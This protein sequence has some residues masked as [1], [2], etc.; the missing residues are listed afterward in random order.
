MI[1]ASTSWPM[2]SCYCGVNHISSLTGATDWYQDLIN[3]HSQHR[4][5]IVASKPAGIRASVCNHV[6]RAEEFCT[7]LGNVVTSL[8]TL[9]YKELSGFD[10]LA[11]A[12][13]LLWG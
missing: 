10:I 12:F 9:I 13:L 8:Y 2:L 6:L 7:L 4:M 1:P 5:I 11:G 3:Y